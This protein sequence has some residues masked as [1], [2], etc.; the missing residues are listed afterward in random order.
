MASLIDYL[1]I[2]AFSFVGVHYKFGGN[3]PLDGLDCSGYVNEV[4]KASGLLRYNVDYTAQNLYDFLSIPD[5]GVSLSEP[6]AGAVSFYGSDGKIN[7]VGFCVDNRMMLEA[8]GGSAQTLTKDDARVANAFIKL[9]PI[10][11]RKD[12]VAIILPNY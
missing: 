6:R 9:R 1:V 3:N 11:Y 10:K 2:Y 12:L 7:H 5:V 4:L 8:G